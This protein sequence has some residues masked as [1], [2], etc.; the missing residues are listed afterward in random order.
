MPNRKFGFL[1]PNERAYLSNQGLYH[2]PVDE[3]GPKRPANTKSRIKNEVGEKFHDVIQE[4]HRDLRGLSN[5]Q[6]QSGFKQK[7]VWENATLVASKDE[8]VAL[9]DTIDRL[10]DRA[11]SD[12]V[13]SEREEL[14]Q[15][16]HIMYNETNLGE[17]VYNGVYSDSGERLDQEELDEFYN[18]RREMNQHL[19]SILS[20]EGLPEILE[21]IGKHGPC[22]LDGQIG[23]EGEHWAQVASRE[24]VDA[25]LAL[26]KEKSTRRKVYQLTSRGEAILECWRALQDT[27]VI[28]FKKQ[29]NPNTDVQKLVLE[30]LSEHFPE[31]YSC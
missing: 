2:P 20:K 22:E 12:A 18:R 26:K 15:A 6:Q 13:N 30:V 1:R 31:N 23:D 9:R 28:T 11:E 16:L 27:E 24:L 5:F 19:H 25:Q 4:F 8:L 21:Y 10:I 14:Q 17:E 3:E 29:F 7:D